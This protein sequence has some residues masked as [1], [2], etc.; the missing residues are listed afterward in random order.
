M[1]VGTR[2]AGNVNVFAARGLLLLGRTDASSLF[3]TLTS[4]PRGGVALFG[5]AI[6][7]LRVAL[8]ARRRSSV[9]V[10]SPPTLKSHSERVAETAV[11]ESTARALGN[12]YPVPR[13]CA[14]SVHPR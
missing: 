12:L 1:T 3:L 9:D 8:F 11:C 6:R 5:V 13:E 7:M 14:F 2:R 4:Y 10:Q